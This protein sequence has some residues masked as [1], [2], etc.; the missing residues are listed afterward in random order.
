MYKTAISIKNGVM[1]GNARFVIKLEGFEGDKED[2]KNVYEDQVLP[3]IIATP[4]PNPPEVTDPYPEGL[5]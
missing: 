1:N 4:S 5:A 3:E 2:L